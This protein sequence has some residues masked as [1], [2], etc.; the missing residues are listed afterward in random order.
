MYNL[1]FQHK[2][3]KNF[4]YEYHFYCFAD[5]DVADV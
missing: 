2:F 4:A 3:Y 5:T 1:P